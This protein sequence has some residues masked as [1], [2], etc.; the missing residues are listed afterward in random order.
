MTKNLRKTRHDLPAKTRAAMVDLLNDS[1][2][3]AIGRLGR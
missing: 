1:L 2:A 3:D